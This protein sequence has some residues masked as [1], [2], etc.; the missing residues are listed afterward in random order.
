[1]KKM[2][3]NFEMAITVGAI[4][5]LASVAWNRYYMSYLSRREGGGAGE[6]AHQERRQAVL[7][8]INAG[9]GKGYVAVTSSMLMNNT[10]SDVSEALQYVRPTKCVYNLLEMLYDEQRGI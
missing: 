1:M 2:N 6:N 10:D 3:Y 8:A 9:G 7:S 5:V 4:L